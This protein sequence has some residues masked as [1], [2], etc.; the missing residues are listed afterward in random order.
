MFFMFTAFLILIAVGI[1][2][3]FSLSLS[4]ILFILYSGETFLITMF[5]QRMFAGTTSFPLLAI[6]FFILTGLLMN[7][8]G[9]T[10]RIFDFASNLVGHIT[11]GLGHVNIVAS[12]IFAGMS[13]SAVADASGLG[14]IEVKAMEDAGYDREFS[15]AITA[16]S[17]TVGPIIPPSIPFVLFGGL[18]G[19]SVGRLFLGGFIPGLLMGLA[20]MVVVYFISKKRGYPKNKRASLIVIAKSFLNA[21]PALT[22]PLII[23]GG[24]LSGYFTPTEASIVAAF[25]A[26]ILGVFVYKEITFHSFFESLKETMVHTIRVLFIIA[27]ASFFAW[28]ITYHGVSRAFAST[29]ISVTDN[30]FFV[31]LIINLIALL[32]G[33]FMEAIAIMILTIPV[34]MPLVN[35]VGIDPVHFGVTLTLTLMLGLITPPVGMCLYAVS[36]MCKIPLMKVVRESIWYYVILVAVLILLIFVP[37]LVTYIPNL[38]MGSA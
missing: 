18:T 6:P 33:C 23:I 38:L 14:A 13:G 4:S 8:G 32:M 22:V 30:P 10:K 3:A 5:A 24:I 29:I 15:A 36:G 20:L 26:F 7:M 16:A 35:Q 2:I 31:L 17:S 34:F 28:L 37:W 25:Y 12:M 9:V 11:G 21:L 19:V 1:P 27:A